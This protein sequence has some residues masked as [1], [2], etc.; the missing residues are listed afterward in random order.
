MARY[1]VRQTLLTA[2]YFMNGCDISQHR[3]DC[4]CVISRRRLTE[5]WCGV[6]DSAVEQ[7]CCDDDTESTA[8][9][10]VTVVLY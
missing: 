9:D 10:A 1:S 6:R 5:C 4:V 3:A 7:R 8:T 2:L